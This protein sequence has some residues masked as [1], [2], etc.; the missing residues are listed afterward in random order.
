MS[1]TTKNA[2]G[3]FKTPGDVW[4]EDMTLR[5]FFAAAVL[6]G[7][8]ANPHSGADLKKHGAD[9]LGEACYLA[10]DNML[11]ARQK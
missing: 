1:E 11:K 6:V 2:G 3:F 10:A 5:D 8:C 7:I 4:A 9:K